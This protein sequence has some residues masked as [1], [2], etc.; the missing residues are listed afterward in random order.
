[1]TIEQAKEILGPLE[2]ESNRLWDE[3]KPLKAAH[4][5]KQDEWVEVFKQVESLKK[6]IEIGERPA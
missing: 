6:F 2:V 1:M 5:A 3:L 4:E